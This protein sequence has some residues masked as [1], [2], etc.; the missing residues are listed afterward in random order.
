M[1]RNLFFS[2][3]FLYLLRV[4]GSYCAEHELA[5]GTYGRRPHGILLTRLQ[6]SENIL[7]RSSSSAYPHFL[8]GACSIAD[9]M[10]KTFCALWTRTG[11]Y[12]LAAVKAGR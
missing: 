11:R 6:V 9:L 5:F 7:V 8:F 12:N 4:D 1:K 3:D 2:A 10:Q